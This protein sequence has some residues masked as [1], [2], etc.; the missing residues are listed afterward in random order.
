MLQV[1]RYGIRHSVY[2][3]WIRE[4]KADNTTTDADADAPTPSIGRA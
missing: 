4:E 2:L 3:F 1:G